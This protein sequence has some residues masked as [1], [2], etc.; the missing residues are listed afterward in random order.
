MTMIFH[1]MPKVKLYLM[2]L[3]DINR[4]VGY[5]TLGVSHDTSEFACKCIR[6]W[7]LEHGQA[8]YEGSTNLLLLCD[9]GGSNNARYYI[10]KEDLEKLSEELKINIRIAHYPPYTSKYNPIEHRL[11]PQWNYVA[12]PVDL[13]SSGFIKS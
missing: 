2:G 7:W 6:Q 1:P 8:L 3:Y 12:V 4:N 11:F 10:F 9:C 13:V 5:I